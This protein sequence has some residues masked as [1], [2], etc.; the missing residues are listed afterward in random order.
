MVL[1]DTNAWVHHL[2]KRDP[3]LVLFLSQQRVRTC[4]V[5]LGELQL[6]S[7]LPKGV[8][9]DLA[10]LPH[11][12]SPGAE[13]T[14]KFIERHRASFAGSGVG[15]ADAQIIVTVVKAGARLH[16][17]DRYVRRLCAAIGVALA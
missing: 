12:P 11:L 7:G 8:A 13:E 5:V 9:A 14:R 4:D 1:V 6:G 16:T 15:W 10:A 3:R 2:R 17:S